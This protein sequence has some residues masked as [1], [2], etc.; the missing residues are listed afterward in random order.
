MIK[1]FII[2]SGLCASLMCTSFAQVAINPISKTLPLK[3]K[4]LIVE[5]IFPYQIYDYSPLLNIVDLAKDKKP[6]YSHP[7]STIQAYFHAMKSLDYDAYMNCWTKDSQIM[8]REKDKL[9]KFDSTKWK[10]LWSSAFVG[11][12]IQISNWINY[13][14]YVLLHYRVSPTANAETSEMTVALTLEN[15]E[16][17]LTQELR[18]DQILTSWN[19]PTGRV[20]VPSDSMLT[21]PIGK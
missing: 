15:G 7:E 21:K 4:V 16:W 13:A 20:R 14:G 10:A 18:T 1:K 17:K 2:I 6:S 3:S 11:K 12:N 5:T 8:M 19:N 9:I